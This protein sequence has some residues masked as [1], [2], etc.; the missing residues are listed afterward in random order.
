M[1]FKTFNEY[2]KQLS[3][4]FYEK[5]PKAVFAALA[6]SFVMRAMGGEFEDVQQHLAE[7]WAVLHANGVIPQKPPKK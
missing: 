5:C 3:R 1:P 7:E 6:V 2:Q 4:D